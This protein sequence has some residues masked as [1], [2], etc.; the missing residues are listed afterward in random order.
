MNVTIR[1]EL[2][3]AGLF[4]LAVS[5]LATVGYTREPYTL[6]P[7]GSGVYRGEVANT[8]AKVKEDE[9]QKEDREKGHRKR[10]ARR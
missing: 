6:D 8:E 4:F 2:R 3:R 1:I 5:I 7:R 10:E 9:R